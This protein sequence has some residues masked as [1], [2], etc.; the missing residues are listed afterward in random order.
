MIRLTRIL[1]GGV[2]S[3]LLIGCRAPE[4]PVSE[5]PHNFFF[6]PP[7][8]EPSDFDSHPTV[9][10]SFDGLTVI[11]TWDGAG[12]VQFADGTF[13][14][15]V[16]S[17]FSKM[18]LQSVLMTK[19]LYEYLSQMPLFDLGA[20]LGVRER[21]V[22]VVIVQV[23]VEQETGGQQA[24]LVARKWMADKTISVKALTANAGMGAFDSQLTDAELKELHRVLEEE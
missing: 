4:R 19:E 6:L 8:K 7:T 22:A 5:V 2:A 24:T 23:L 11:V 3:L 1:L 14:V 15:V 12:A 13:V 21:I 9:R 16:E 10:Y 17:V 18:N 20:V